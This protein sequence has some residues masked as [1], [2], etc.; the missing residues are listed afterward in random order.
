[1]PVPTDMTNAPAA[2]AGDLNSRL[3][4]HQQF[5]SKLMDEKHDFIVYLPPMY[6]EQ[7]TAAFPCSTCRTGRTCSIPRHVL[8]QGQL[9]AHG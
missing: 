9:L 8:H 1:M 5:P 3:R 7:P 6:D 2:V 4:L